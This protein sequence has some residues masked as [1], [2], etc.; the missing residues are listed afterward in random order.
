[1]QKTPQKAPNNPKTCMCVVRV[2]LT[3][4]TNEAEENSLNVV[5]VAVMVAYRRR[6]AVCHLINAVASQD[7]GAVSL[8]LKMWKAFPCE[9]PSLHL[10]LLYAV[11]NL[12]LR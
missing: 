11:E 5:D 12:G 10:R 6:Q 7:Q 8:L 1:M 2:Q 3:M 9:H 4:N